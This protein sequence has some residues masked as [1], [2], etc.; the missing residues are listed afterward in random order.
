MSN[1]AAIAGM[2]AY[3]EMCKKKQDTKVKKPVEIPDAKKMKRGG[4]S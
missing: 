3:R 4:K 1:V 2:L